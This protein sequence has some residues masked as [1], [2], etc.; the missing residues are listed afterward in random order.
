VAILA[1]IL[2]KKINFTETSEAVLVSVILA[3]FHKN[4][5]KPKIYFLLKITLIWRLYVK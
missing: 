1:K 4:A 5:I 3:F 2:K